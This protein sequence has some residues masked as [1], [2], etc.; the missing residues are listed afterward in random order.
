MRLVGIVLVVLASSGCA[1]QAGDP[2]TGEEPGAAEN[3]G[4]ADHPVGQP[5]TGKTGVSAVP[6]EVAETAVASH[7]TTT[8]GSTSVEGAGSGGG[9]MGSSTPDNPNPSPWNTG[10]TST[11]APV[12]GSLA[13]GP[14]E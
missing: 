3:A 10:T 7:P 5:T 13:V 1:M 4:P 12:A 14:R 6:V 9:N 2:S 11:Q 8:S